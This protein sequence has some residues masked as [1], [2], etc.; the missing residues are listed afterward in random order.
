MPVHL[1]MPL[2]R[3][4]IEAHIPHQ[5]RM[6]LI[7]EVLEWNTERIRCASGGHRAADHPLRAHGRL[8]VAC[9]VEIAAQTMAVHAALIAARSDT[10]PSA[11]LLAS[12]RA[13]RMHVK[14]LDDVQSELICDAVCM[15]G[16][17]DTALYE[18]ELRERRA[19]A[20]RLLSGRAAVVL[21]ARGAS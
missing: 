19:A 8:G 2:R 3:G 21:N 14:R 18:F 9:G 16:D 20:A 12:L 1:V 10:R 13:V 11:G 7:D 5:G 4:W 17:G 6:C 15:A